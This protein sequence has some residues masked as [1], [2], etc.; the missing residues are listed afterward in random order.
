MAGSLLLESENF[1]GSTGQ[2]TQT[3]LRVH[4]NDCTNERFAKNVCEIQAFSAG[5]QLALFFLSHRDSRF[6]VVADRKKLVPR[7]NFT[8][9]GFSMP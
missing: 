6:G 3:L 1:F 4:N 5:L 2:E 9:A 7:V 8:A